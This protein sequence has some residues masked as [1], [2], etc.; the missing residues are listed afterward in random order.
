MEYGDESG[1][2]ERPSG[3]WGAFED[4]EPSPRDSSSGFFPFVFAVALLA[5]A[6]LLVSALRAW[7][8]GPPDDRTLWEK[9][10]GK[11]R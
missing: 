10:Q 6:A 4:L 9:M 7:T 1:W 3:L 5:G 2:G 8:P 11:P